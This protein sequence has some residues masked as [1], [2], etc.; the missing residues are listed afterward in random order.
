MRQ[1]VTQTSAGHAQS[2]N[3]PAAYVTYESQHAAGMDVAQGVRRKIK[4]H[5]LTHQEISA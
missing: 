4:V 1:L 3:L 5:V 2:A